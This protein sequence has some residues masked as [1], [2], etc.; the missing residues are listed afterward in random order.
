M[1]E[2]RKGVDVA[3]LTHRMGRWGVLARTDSLAII[4]GSLA[5]ASVLAAIL[6]PRSGLPTLAMVFEPHLYIAAI[7]VLAPLAF[8]R[9]ARTLAAVL[10]IIAIIGGSLF[11]SEWIS[12]PGSGAGRHDIS[13]MTWN[14]Q[15]GTR[16]PA[17][18]AAQ[19]ETVSADL[20]ALME[21]EPDASDAIA[22]D[23]ILTSRFPFRV[24]APRP[25]AWGLAI[26]SR[27][28]ISDVLSIEDPSCL[29]LM[30][31]TPQGKVHVIAAHPNH[32]DIDTRTPLRLPVGYD[33]TGRD[34]AI[35][36]VR[37]RIDAALAAGD[38][39]LVLGDYNTTPSEPEYAALSRGLRDTHEEVG[40]G[41]GWT[42]R[43]SR[44]DFL[45]F[46]F[47]RID[48]Q[49]SAGKIRPVSTSIDCSL[50][51]DHCRLFGDYE[52]D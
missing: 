26:L 39:L 7:V 45:P 36:R 41:P 22:A 23:P 51:G 46:G 35:A 37:T 48:L 17:A 32:A 30:V 15:Y 18:Q 31:A 49:M 20:V 12:L 14:V 52:I 50:P 33:P 38:R 29:D 44:I 25:G 3:H 13:V 19:L 43:P 1:H 28:P 8:W 9:R 42:W 2:N 5:L 16:T 24:L 4:P 21:V 11:G 47:L 10:A 34:A 6:P 40:E 27:Y